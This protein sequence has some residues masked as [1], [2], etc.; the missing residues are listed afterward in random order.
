MRR[1]KLL[2]SPMYT[3]TFDI[4]ILSQNPLFWSLQ[5][6]A[7]SSLSVLQVKRQILT[8][9]FVICP[10]TFKSQYLNCLLSFLILCHFSFRSRVCLIDK[11]MFARYEVNNRCDILCLGRCVAIGCGCW[12]SH[13]TPI[14]PIGEQ[15]RANVRMHCTFVDLVSL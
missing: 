10:Q 14:F 12:G 11:G 5:L 6:S 13:T 3:I 2:S 9:I 15:L 4:T 7:D 1:I 8:I